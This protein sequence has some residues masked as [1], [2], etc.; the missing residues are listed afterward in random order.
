VQTVAADAIEYEVNNFDR[1]LA[2]VPCSGTGTLSKKPDIKWKRDLL[3][4]HKLTVLQGKLLS[5][6]SKLVKPGGI[7]VYST[8]SIEPEENFGI[9]EK[10]LQDNPD[11]TLLNAGEIFPN[12]VVDENGC[13]QTLPHIHF[14]D[15]AFAAKLMRKE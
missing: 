15:G 9:V 1:V 11:F 12:S 5:K 8:C 4:I 10:F 2:D 6:A 14:M 13:T 7:V 3:D